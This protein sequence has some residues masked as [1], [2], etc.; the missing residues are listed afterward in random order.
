[1]DWIIFALL[2]LLFALII[3]TLQGC[4]SLSLVIRSII[5]SQIKITKQEIATYYGITRKTLDKWIRFIPTNL[6]YPK[7]KSARKLS[8]YNFME[9]INELGEVEKQK[10][11][12]KYTIKEL[13]ETRYQTI[14]ENISLTFCGITKEIYIKMNVFPPIVSKKIIVHLSI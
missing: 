5:L 4:L 1:M 12:Y 13:C 2:I 6:S 9:I 8:Y 10:P 3:D 11:L 14:R 7:Y